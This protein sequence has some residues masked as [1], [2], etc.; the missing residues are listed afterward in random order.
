M[1]GKGDFDP[2]KLMEQAVEVMRQSV[3]EPRGDGKACPKVGA[4]LL[5]PDG[6]VETACRGE[7]RDG[8]HAEYTLLERKNRGHKLDGSILFATL[9]PCAPDARYPPKMGCAE[10]IVLARIKEVWVGIEDPDPTV[11]RKGIKYLQDRG[12]TVRMFDRDLQEEI[13]E[14]NK[15]FIHEAL[16]RASAA[17]EEK[18][19]EVVSLSSLENPFAASATTDFSDEALQQFREIAK[20][21]DEVGSAAFNRRLVQQGLLKQENGQFTPTGFGLLLF[22]KEPR[23]SL[24]QAGLLGTLHFP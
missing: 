13:Q 11:D 3:D 4:V 24:P 15:D 1:R 18:K 5:K 2:R 17:E 9:E 22:G 6:S 23:T 16:E 7:L 10:R 8:D 20:I 12:V 14:A 21:K 19:P